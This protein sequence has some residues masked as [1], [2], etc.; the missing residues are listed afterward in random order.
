MEDH[1]FRNQ[2]VLLDISFLTQP[3]PTANYSYFA[4]ISAPVLFFLSPESAHLLFIPFF[5]YS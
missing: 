5:L 1:R 2:Q 4:I 3:S